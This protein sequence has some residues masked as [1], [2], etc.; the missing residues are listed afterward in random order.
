[1][2]E[3]TLRWGGKTIFFPEKNPPG[4]LLAPGAPATFP[5]F[6]PAR[7][8]SFK[9]ELGQFWKGPYEL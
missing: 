4:S 8:V 5:S 3:A 7:P 1:M 2:P 9:Q 6:R